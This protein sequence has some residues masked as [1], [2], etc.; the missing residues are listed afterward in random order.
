M[1]HRSSPNFGASS[2]RGKSY[3]LS[4]PKMGDFFNNS[5]GHPVFSQSLG[6]RD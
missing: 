6:E 5:S 3:S 2:F 4:L 1:N